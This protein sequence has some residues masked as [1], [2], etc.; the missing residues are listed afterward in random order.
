MGQTTASRLSSSIII[1]IF[2]ALI[3]TQS[4]LLWRLVGRADIDKGRLV[5]WE[6]SKPINNDK[7]HVIKEMN[8]CEDV[9]IHYA[10]NTAFAACGDPVERRSWYPCAGM[11][12]APQRSEAS[13]REYLFKHDLKTGKSTQLELRGL[14]GDFITHGIDIFSIPESASKVPSAVQGPVAEVRAKYCQIHIFAVNHARD[15]DSIVIFSHELGSDTVDLVKKVRHPN[16]KTAN[17]V[18]ATGPG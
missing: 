12:D 7:C 10:S 3:Y 17:G 18:V 1:L 14:E 5:K 11:R 13:F 15:G 6:N 4:G 8:A 2:A 16:I 9:K